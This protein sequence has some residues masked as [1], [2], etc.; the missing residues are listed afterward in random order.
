M[1][2]GSFRALARLAP[3]IL[4]AMLAAGAAAAQ[5]EVHVDG[6]VV[7]YDGARQRMS[8][9]AH[10]TARILNPKPYAHASSG[11]KVTG[12][13]APAPPPEVATAIHDAAQRHNVDEGL[14]Q[15]VAYQESRYNTS[16]VS[17]KGAR[18]AMQ[19]MPATAQT[20][21]VDASSTAGNIEG[22][23]VYLS[24]MMNRYGGD[25]EK[26]LAAYNAGPGAV[27]RYGGVPPYRETQ[28]YVH[29][30]MGRLTRTGGVAAE[31][32][33]DMGPLKVRMSASSE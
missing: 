33:P 6:S 16:A 21:G 3:A 13:T 29:S 26:A 30:I 5:E 14:V 18:G 20:L 25:T 24:K 22:G 19:L 28:G 10:P 15:A 2:G 8:P 12:T 32:E 27:D 1:V 7:I 11:A 31:P 23:V 4:V 9:G 17:G